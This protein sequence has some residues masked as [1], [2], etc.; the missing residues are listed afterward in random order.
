MRPF[1]DLDVLPLPVVAISACLAGDAV[2][3][4]GDHK[5]Q[6]LLLRTL[7]RRIRWLHICPEMAAGLGVPRPPVQLRAGAEGIAVVEVDDPAR[8]HTAALQQGVSDIMQQLRMQR[9]AA[10]VLKA[11]SP[12]CGTG[13]TPLFN[14]EGVAQALTDGV[15]AHACRQHFP[16]IP[17]LD[18]AA[19]MTLPACQTLALAL[20]IRTDVEHADASHRPAIEAHYGCFGIEIDLSQPQRLMSQ[21]ADWPPRRIAEAFDAMWSE[22]DGVRQ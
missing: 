18:E 15:F 22:H 11:R 3:Y 7:D 17:L 5:L 20:L 1:H 14:H 2:R 13:S 9:P 4:D 21:I 12:S 8:D 16:D 19:L 6:P 10:I